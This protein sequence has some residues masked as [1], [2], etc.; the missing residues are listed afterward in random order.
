MLFTIDRWEKC[1]KVRIVFLCF[2]IQRPILQWWLHFP[3]IIYIYIYYDLALLISYYSS[4]QVGVKD[5]PKNTNS[6]Y[7]LVQR[8]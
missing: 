5:V 1:T 4:I 6:T 3:C 2:T 8:H 7:Q